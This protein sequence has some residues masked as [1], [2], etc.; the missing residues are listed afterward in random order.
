MTKSFIT[1]VTKLYDKNGL[2]DTTDETNV[3]EILLQSLIYERDE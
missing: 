1:A 3:M 2:I